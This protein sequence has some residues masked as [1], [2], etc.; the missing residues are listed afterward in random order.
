M[1]LLE[2]CQVRMETRD[3]LFNIQ[4]LKNSK[5]KH[6]YIFKSYVNLDIFFSINTFWSVLDLPEAH[7]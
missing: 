7:N 3:V 5:T 1:A 2:V 6:V 4:T